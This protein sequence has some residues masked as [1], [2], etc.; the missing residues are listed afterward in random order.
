M[1][2]E[3]WGRG[4]PQQTDLQKHPKTKVNATPIICTLCKGQNISIKYIQVAEAQMCSQC[5]KTLTL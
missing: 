5:Y 1:V 3:S 2:R 4:D